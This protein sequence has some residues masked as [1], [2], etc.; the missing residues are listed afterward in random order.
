MHYE[1]V[2]CIP[3]PWSA[4]VPHCWGRAVN[5]SL[6]SK[7]TDITVSSGV[8]AGERQMPEIGNVCTL[9]VSFAILIF[10]GFTDIHTSSHLIYGLIGCDCQYLSC[11]SIYQLFSSTEMPTFISTKQHRWVSE[12]F[13]IFPEALTSSTFSKSDS[14]HIAFR[15]GSQTG[16]IARGTPLM[17]CVVTESFLTESWR[18][19]TSMRLKSK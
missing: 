1:L 16:V 10:D 15:V 18:G 5:T 3:I 9:W 12:I 13:C 19:Q 2:Y 11:V 4:H 8:T 14:C 17:M 6:S 7:Y